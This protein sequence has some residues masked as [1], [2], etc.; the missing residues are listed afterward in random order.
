MKNNRFWNKYTRVG[1]IIVMALVTAIIT[2]GVNS[3]YRARVTE[4]EKVVVAAGHLKPYTELT[5]ANLTY[6]E[7]VKSEIPGDAIKS[8]DAFLKKGP[9]FVGE[10]GLT[11]GYPVKESLTLD[12][13]KSVFGE[14]L[15]L[16]N[17]KLLV[18]IAVNQVRSV[19][20]LIKPG[21]KVSAY[22]FIDGGIDRGQPR[23]ITPLDNPGLSN[24]VVVERQNTN[25]AE[26][27][28][29]GADAIPVMVIVE[30]DPGQARDLVLYQEIGK[31]YTLPT[32]VDPSVLYKEGRN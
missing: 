4:V 32:G 6:R 19:G 8:I 17:N 18:A 5:K 1:V 14:A 11:K 21:V 27:N 20:D 2:M 12:S 29:K 26:P 3:S 31:I 24:L 25:G 10:V 7:V 13:G 9:K 28:G 15:G 22:V 16:K 30:A 23:V